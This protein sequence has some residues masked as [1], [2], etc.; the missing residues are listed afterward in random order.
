MYNIHAVVIDE[1]E[2]HDRKFENSLRLIR[3]KIYYSDL[4]N[5]IYYYLSS[6]IN[7]YFAFITSNLLVST[8]IHNI[9]IYMQFDNLIA[10]KASTGS[11]STSLLLTKQ[12]IYLSH[13]TSTQTIYD[14]MHYSSV[15]AYSQKTKSQPFRKS[16]LPKKMTRT[17]L[18]Q[19]SAKR[20]I[21]SKHP[22]MIVQTNLCPSML[23]K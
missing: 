23:S 16:P 11:M 2:C 1:F 15:I 3:K 5:I 4:F 10:I 13:W 9:Y 8:A 19:H 18:H 6:K 12:R 22:M 20:F 14:M 7:G 21:M 17:H